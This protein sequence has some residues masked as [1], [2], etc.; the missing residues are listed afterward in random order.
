MPCFLFCLFDAWTMLFK[1]LKATIIC[2]ISKMHIYIKISAW[3][4]ANEIAISALF[5]QILAETDFLSIDEHDMYLLPRAHPDQ[6]IFGFHIRHAG[7]LSLYL[8]KVPSRADFWFWCLPQW[9]RVQTDTQLCCNRLHNYVSQHFHYEFGPNNGSSERQQSAWFH[10]V[11]LLLS[12]VV[13][14]LRECLEIQLPL[15]DNQLCRIFDHNF[16][17]RV[18]LHQNW[19]ARCLLW[20]SIQNAKKR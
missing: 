13:L 6:L 3:A 9:G 11:R 2:T 18:Y 4:H 5:N 20:K 16:C 14:P 12:S 1:P 10:F 17:G 8:E 7:T 19:L 15:A